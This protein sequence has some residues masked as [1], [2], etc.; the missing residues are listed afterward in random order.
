MKRFVFEGPDAVKDCIVEM[1][2]PN[3]RQ[4]V[5]QFESGGT[6]HFL[7]GDCAPEFSETMLGLIDSGELKRDLERM[8]E[9]HGNVDLTS[10]P[11]HPFDG[12]LEAPAFAAMTVLRRL[13]A[14]W[15]RCKP[16]A[17]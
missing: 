12:G 7:Y 17:A 13:Y 10:L 9:E 1:D 4:Q 15:Q 16:K 14:S 8:H 5:K 6:F 11:E 2:I 3:L